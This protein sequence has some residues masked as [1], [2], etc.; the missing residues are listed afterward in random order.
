MNSSDSFGKCLKL[1]LAVVQMDRSSKAVLGGLANRY[2]L[3]ECFSS[4]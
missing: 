4:C 2:L 1:L 3:L